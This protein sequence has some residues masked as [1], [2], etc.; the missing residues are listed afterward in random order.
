MSNQAISLLTLSVL[1]AGPLTKYRAVTSVG[2][3]A[4]TDLFGI[5]GADG[6]AAGDCVPVHVT[7][8]AAIEAGA[9]IPVGTKY[10]IADAQG[11]A[12]VGGTVA[13]CLGKVCPGQAAGA[14]G[15]VIE[16]LL[17]MEV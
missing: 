12:I 8:T 7:G 4:A 11:R 13:A 15:D 5:T 10:V 2:A 16:V 14:A 6:A 9:A 3:H 17:R 1:A